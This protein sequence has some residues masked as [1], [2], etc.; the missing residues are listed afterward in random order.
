MEESIYYDSN[1]LQILTLTVADGVP[2]KMNAEGSEVMVYAG[3][4]SS[5]YWIDVKGNADEEAAVLDYV[6]HG[7]EQGKIDL[8]DYEEERISVIKVGSSYYCRK[9]PH[10]SIPLNEEASE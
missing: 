6:A 2:V 3:E 7:I 5:L 4:S 10:T 1:G 9:V 8:F